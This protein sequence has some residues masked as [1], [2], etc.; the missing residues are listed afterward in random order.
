MDREN[1][2]RLLLILDDVSQDGLLADEP[3]F[4]THGEE[5]DAKDDRMSDEEEEGVENLFPVQAAFLQNVVVSVTRE[6]KQRKSAR[7]LPLVRQTSPLFKP[8][9][10]IVHLIE[11]RGISGADA[12]LVVIPKGTVWLGRYL[13]F[14]E[15]ERLV[16]AVGDGYALA[17]GRREGTE[18]RAAVPLMD[19]INRALLDA[20]TKALPES[21]SPRAAPPELEKLE[22]ELLGLEVSSSMQTEYAK[23]MVA[24]HTRRIEELSRKLETRVKEAAAGREDHF[25]ELIGHIS[26]L[27]ENAR[28][29]DFAQKTIR[30][31]RG[32]GGKV[33]GCDLTG[34]IGNPEKN[35]WRDDTAIPGV[36]LYYQALDT[37]S[38]SSGSLLFPVRPSD[39][40]LVAKLE[41]RDGRL[42]IRRGATLTPRE[43]AEM[44]RA[45]G[46]TL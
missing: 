39:R 37:A 15:G 7:H 21:S 14:R 1:A 26:R 13:H 20:K 18:R 30:K 11:G 29:L 27:S 24:K 34:S 44:S 3:Q 43:T 38:S 17:S 32:A 22:S 35:V 45:G 23:K 41:L 25:L 2:F 46:W 10:G 6:R 19:P 8:P 4:W 40:A 28:L 5:G 36:E 33:D 42:E 9:G 31:K 16:I 12:R